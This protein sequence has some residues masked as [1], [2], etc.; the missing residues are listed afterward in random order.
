MAWSDIPPA[1]HFAELSEE[2]LQRWSRFGDTER[3]H[4]MKHLSISLAEVRNGYCRLV[5]PLRPEHLNLPGV[6]HG[7]TVSA[8]LDTVV[9]PAVAAAYDQPVPMV[10][11][12]MHVSFVGSVRDQDVEAIGWVT[13]RGRS[14][15]FCRAAV[16]TT[17]GKRVADAT[18]IYKVSLPE[19]D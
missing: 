4:L 19:G 17:D 13:R 18:V 1:D 11:V 16:Q 3:T 2:Q 6:L 15:V 7:G 5:M 8:L 9:V 10:T 12:D 14:V